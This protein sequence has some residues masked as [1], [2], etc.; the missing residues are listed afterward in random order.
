VSVWLRYHKPP[1]EPVIV[2]FEEMSPDQMAQF[3][4]RCAERLGLTIDRGPDPKFD[5]I[6]RERQAAADR[7]RLRR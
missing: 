4:T 6:M 2:E 7:A 3:L 1:A 5:Q